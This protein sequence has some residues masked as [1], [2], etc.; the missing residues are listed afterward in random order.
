[1]FVNNDV[2]QH[3]GGKKTS[4][5]NL[6]LCVYLYDRSIAA[7]SLFEMLR[8]SIKVSEFFHCFTIKS[9]IYIQANNCNI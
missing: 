2:A 3:A 4:G 6:S 9:D 5:A 1:M 8:K 7:T